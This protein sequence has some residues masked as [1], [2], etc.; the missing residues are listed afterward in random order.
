MLFCGIPV[1]AIRSEEAS[2][3]VVGL[4]ANN[5]FIARFGVLSHIEQQQDRIIMGL[6][7]IIS[8]HSDALPLSGIRKPFVRHFN[9]PS[10][11]NVCT[12]CTTTI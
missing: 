1:S 9:G 10:F 2:R 5:R 4:C 12:I 3:V 8:N 7:N 6:N 11:F